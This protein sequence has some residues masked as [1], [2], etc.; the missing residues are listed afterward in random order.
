MA[1]PAAQGHRAPAWLLRWALVA[2]LGGL[3]A[4]PARAQPAAAPAAEGA[5]TAAELA[6]LLEAASGED[7]GRV[8][9]LLSFERMRCA[10][11]E[12]KQVALLKRPLR[13][14]G[15]IVFDRQKGIARH[16]AKPRP[17]QAVVTRTTLRLTRGKR[18]EEIS[19]DKSKELRAFALVFPALLRGDRDELERSFELVAL[20]SAKGR[21]A[22]RL[23]PRG[24][25]LRKLV[26][27]VLVVGKGATLHLLEVE[28][29]SG[30]RSRTWLT[31]QRAGAEV[32]GEE[33]A[34]AFGGA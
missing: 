31:E 33:L 7:P 5:P 34:A 4:A 11:A 24:A 9:A 22:L 19:L 1:R 21:W 25:A 2:L 12:E 3:A 26:R 17:S 6:T 30:D 27:R 20:G 8:L 15:T 16:T 10:F 28:E 13:S 32:S 18:V 29:A 23:T 14:S